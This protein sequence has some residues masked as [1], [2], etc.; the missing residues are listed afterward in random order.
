VPTTE[1]SDHGRERAERHPAQLPSPSLLTGALDVRPPGKRAHRRHDRTLRHYR[2]P[3]W[4]R[5]PPDRSVAIPVSSLL[6]MSEPVVKKSRW[7]PVAPACQRFR[8]S[9]CAYANRPWSTFRSR[10]ASKFRYD[11]RKPSVW[12][13]EGAERQSPPVTALQIQAE[14]ASR[15][16][17]RPGGTPAARQIAC[18]SAELSVGSSRNAARRAP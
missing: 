10:F 16:G 12:G 18:Q 1:R 5:A 17:P 6:S 14:T 3:A 11:L 4:M 2:F 8:S 13:A 15:R 7:F 9:P